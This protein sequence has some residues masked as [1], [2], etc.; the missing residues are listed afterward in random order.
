MKRES[1]LNLAVKKDIFEAVCLYIA[2][3]F[4]M[5]HDWKASSYWHVRL[6]GRTIQF[7]ENVCTDFVKR[8]YCTKAELFW[9]KGRYNV[10]TYHTYPG[11]FIW[12]SGQ[13]YFITSDCKLHTD[14][15]GWFKSSK[16]ITKEH[17]KGCSAPV[18]F[19]ILLSIVKTI[20]PTTQLKST[21]KNVI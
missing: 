2:L 13:C 7:I 9:Y 8:T 1:Y 11:R 15:F 12:A 10:L 5:L 19:A 3:S 4:H 17:L 18:C 21:P 14:R 20:P 6:N 16:F